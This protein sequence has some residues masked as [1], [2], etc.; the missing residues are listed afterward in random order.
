MSNIEPLDPEIVAG[1]PQGEKAAIHEIDLERKHS[2]ADD[3]GKEDQ[4]RYDKIDDEVA[5]YAA[6]EAVHVSPEESLRLRKMIDRRVLVIMIMTYFLQAI[7][8]G[9]LSFAYVPSLHN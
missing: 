2:V 5:K 4:A 9:T 6:A 1:N 3:M 7:D 8:K